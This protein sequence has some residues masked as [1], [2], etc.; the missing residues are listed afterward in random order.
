MPAS[1]QVTAAECAAL[2]ARVV[3]LE[4]TIG[5]VPPQ[6]PTSTHQY[7]DA[8][9]AR[10][11]HWKSYSLR[12]AA[13]IALYRG[14]T[15]ADVTYQF[16]SDSDPRK[17]DAAKV[18]I[19][20]WIG[21][22]ALPGPMSATDRTFMTPV[23]L[24]GAPGVYYKIDDDVLIFR[25]R[26]SGTTTVTRGAHGTTPVPHVTGTPI[27][28][29][30]NSLPSQV[31][32][33]MGTQDGHSYLVVWEAWYGAEIAFNRAA[34]PNYKTFQFDSRR[35]ATGP[36]A[37]WTEINNNWAA[38]P[39][40]A[41]LVQGRYY[42]SAATPAGPG[43]V[44]TPTLGPRVA[45][46]TP[47]LETWTRYFALFEQK[48]GSDPWTRFSLW[49]ADGARDPVKIFDGLPLTT[50]AAFGGITQFW[51]E[52]NTSHDPIAANRG[53]LVSYVRNVW[54]GRDVANVSALLVKP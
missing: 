22:V 13:Q 50:V 19:P 27:H 5:I 44:L 25:S 46:F 20:E 29:G 39:R 30:T 54:M 37:I 1:G 53:P 51:L 42:A 3:A 43:V 47:A 45:E 36:A 49:V 21:G 10:P 15:R 33:P 2:D 38:A 48:V 52:F 11:D 16:S 28:T 31:R 32:L 17:Q 23:G 14:R 41:G 4:E 18:V 6:M 12:D 8:L 26:A 9:V 35:T 7:F 24:Q 40:A 34:I